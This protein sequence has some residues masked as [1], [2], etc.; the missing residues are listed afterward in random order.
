VIPAAGPGVNPPVVVGVDVSSVER[1]RALL[2]RHPEFAVKYFTAEE[3]EYCWGRPERLTARWAAKEAVRKV[4]GTMGWPLPL[5]SRIAVVRRL[6]GAPEVLV[7]EELVD[8]L[9]ISLTH[10][11]GLG[12]AV[13]ALSPLGRQSRWMW[14]RLPEDLQ[15]PSRASSSHKGTFGTVLVVAGSPAFPGAAV[16]CS[17]GAL[18]GGAG[19]VKALVAGPESGSLPPE[20]IRV[21]V[22]ASGSAL[23]PESLDQAQSA[24]KS[25]QAVVC[26]PGLGQDESV[27]GLLEGLFA[28]AGGARWGLVLDA[29]ALN[30]C[31]ASPQ[32][33][34]KIPGGSVLTPHP[35]EAARLAGVE[36]SQIECDRGGWAVRMAK[37]LGVVLV[38]KGAGTVVAAPDGR[39]WTDDHHTSVL[40]TGGTGDVLAGLIGS[41]LAQGL[42]PY[43]AARTGVFLH[44]EAGTRL[45]FLRGRA[46]ILASEVPGALVE[47]QEAARRQQ[48]VV[49]ATAK[50]G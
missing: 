25:A 17:L 22:A 9:A 12:I 42:E 38:L 8:G 34:R 6:G 4:F 24:L 14:S 50:R 20:V 45:G 16:L 46:G 2:Q 29:D 15:L 48:E 32:L 33:R 28:A 13:A 21:P 7:D 37:E 31:S 19:K 36:L 30:V 47:V 27:A 26:G 40:A 35:L 10:D 41:L 3:V 43:Q 18:R 5:Y 11:A 39:T 23:G 49:V 1:V 44:G